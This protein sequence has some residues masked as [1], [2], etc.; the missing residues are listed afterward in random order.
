MQMPALILDFL[1]K[2]LF[3]DKFLFKD[4]FPEQEAPIGASLQQSSKPCSQAEPGWTPYPNFY[5][6]PQ[7]YSVSCGQRWCCCMCQR[8]HCFVKKQ[9]ISFLHSHTIKTLAVIFYCHKL[10]LPS[11]KTYQEAPAFKSKL[12]CYYVQFIVPFTNS[13]WK[14]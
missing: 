7:R 14:P 6:Q 4:K 11:L 12:F 5:H 8:K 2:D 10:C 1:F 3:Q 9:R 13:P